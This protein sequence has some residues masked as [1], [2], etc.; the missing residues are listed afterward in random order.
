[1]GAKLKLLKG[2]IKSW[3][4]NNI[5]EVGK[6]K[7][8]IL[9]EIQSIDKIEEVGALSEDDFG[10]ILHLK[11]DYLKKVKE[12]EIKW[13]QRSRCQWLKDGDRNSKFFHGMASVRSR[14]N[15][16]STLMNA[17]ERLE[18]KQ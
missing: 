6:A 4:A 5:E 8:R 17:E 14:T 7:A 1:M 2:K 13:K 12:E 15:R 16:I 11:E 9:D 18:R 3:V 10:R